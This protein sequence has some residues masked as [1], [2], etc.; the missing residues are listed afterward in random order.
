MRKLI[1]LLTLCLVIPVFAA[2]TTETLPAGSYIK[3]AAVSDGSPAPTFEWFKDGAKVGEGTEYI[4]PQL[5]TTQ[6]GIYTVKATNPSGSV[7]SDKFT[8]LVGGAPT[9][10]R[11]EVTARKPGDTTLT[12][13][14]PAGLKV[15]V[16]QPAAK[17]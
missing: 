12:V 4:I 2:D 3:L 6:G 5:L 17:K 9:F 15:N 10:A 13:I 7:T 11:I 8:I 16:T 14:A 1:L